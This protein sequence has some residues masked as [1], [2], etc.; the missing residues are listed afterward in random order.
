MSRSPRIAALAAV[1]A[2]VLS[3]AAAVPAVA[4]GTN[5]SQ[6]VLS[7]GGRFMGWPSGG[8]GALIRLHTGT[9]GQGRCISMAQPSGPGVPAILWDCIG[10]PVQAFTQHDNLDGSWTYSAV[11]PSSQ[12]RY[13]MDSGAGQHQN[14]TVIAFFSCNGGKSQKWVVG[15]RSQLQ[16]ADSPGMC[17]D[18][19]LA[20]VSNGTRMQMWDCDNDPGPIPASVGNPPTTGSKPAAKTTAPQAT[21]APAARPSKSASTARGKADPPGPTSLH[22]ARSP[23]LRPARSP[24]PARSSAPS[25]SPSTAQPVSPA[26]PMPSGPMPS[27]TVASPPTASALRTPRLQQASAPVSSPPVLIGVCL[28]LI[29][30]CLGVTR[31]LAPAQL[32][33]I[34]VGAVRRIRPTGLS[35]WRTVL[36]RLRR[37]TTP[38]ERTASPRPLAAT[39]ATAA[40]AAPDTEGSTTSD[41]DSP[42]LEQAQSPGTEPGRSI[43][44][45]VVFDVPWDPLEPASAAPWWRPDSGVFTV[46]TQYEGTRSVF[47]LGP[48][49]LQPLLFAELVR[50]QTGRGERPVLLITEVRPADWVLQLMADYLQV[51]VLCGAPGQWWAVPPQ[52]ADRSCA[53]ARALTGP[54]PLRDAD[55]ALLRAAPASDDANAAEPDPDGVIRAA[56]VDER[57]LTF[58][59]PDHSGTKELLERFGHWRRTGGQPDLYGVAVRCA[60]STPGS[61]YLVGR[62]PRSAWELARALWAERSRWQGEG[63]ELALFTD[64]LMPD[65]TLQ[66]RLLSSYLRVPVVNG[67]PV[68]LPVPGGL[69]Q[70]GHSA[71]GGPGPRPERPQSLTPESGA[72]PL[73][74]SEAPA[75]PTA[76][77]S[78][79]APTVTGVP[80]EEPP[81]QAAALAE[82][83]PFGA[84]GETQSAGAEPAEEPDTV[85]VVG[86]GVLLAPPTLLPG[87]RSTPE[88]RSLLR[89]GLRHRYDVHARAVARTLATNPGLRPASAPEQGTD[90][91]DLV[92]IRALLDGDAPTAASEQ[93]AADLA[94][95]WAACVA[96]GLRR[97]PS[98]RGAVCLAGA[99]PGSDPQALVPG[100]VVDTAH[101]LRTSRPAATAPNGV[102]MTVLWSATGRRVGTLFPERTEED[103]VFPGNC[104]FRVVGVEPAGPAT[105]RRVLLREVS[106]EERQQ[107]GGTALDDEDRSVLERLRRTY[108]GPGQKTSAQ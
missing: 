92:A 50:V 59:E 13:C 9:G 20:H 43:P 75:L 26:Q 77:G 97:L 71:V 100:Q 76:V 51:P 33:R 30:L 95:A 102:V 40:A 101:V 87:H 56:E 108:D 60:S 72:E 47:R 105:P 29:V 34:A 74:D 41:V 88:E 83:A 24:S 93:A 54:Y 91:C 53:S 27:W 65:Q 52:R 48:R 57:G 84:P 45:G 22:P 14:G 106:P 42:R 39:A 107:S 78:S 32:R 62:T 49:T 4:E 99:L 64:S 38:D 36:R 31:S 67:R 73:P 37:N 10:S 68:A 16:S 11:D 80:A 103:I 25:A 81:P 28:L 5:L 19:T 55:K 90:M 85:T 69:P 98:Y 2:L 8:G 7:D 79:P 58:L 44:G 18:N 21:S 96:S 94:A 23:S 15:P 6:Q 66:L 17:L 12:R 61:P 82:T 1:L 63:R 89:E 70:G 46:F 35:L 104:A 86:A 3:S